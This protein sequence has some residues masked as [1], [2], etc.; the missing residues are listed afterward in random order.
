MVGRTYD[1]ALNNGTLPLRP[2]I[3]DSVWRSEVLPYAI[4]IL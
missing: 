3:V 1:L 2:N 4:E